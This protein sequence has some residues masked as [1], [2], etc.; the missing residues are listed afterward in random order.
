MSLFSA[1]IG[2]AGGAGWNISFGQ[3]SANLG[4]QV[5]ELLPS[6][7]LKEPGENVTVQATI[8]NN[9]SADA[10]GF[11]VRMKYRAE[12]SQDLQDLFC[13]PASCNNL[14]LSAGKTTVAFGTLDTR[15]LSS[16]RYLILVEIIQNSVVQ[17]SQETSLLI[18][19]DRPEFHPTSLTFSPP[20]PAPKGSLLTVRVQIENT[21]KPVS[22][23]L[24]NIL[25]TLE[26]KFEYCQEITEGACVEFSSQGFQDGTGGTI[27][28]TSAELGALSTGQPLQVTNR[29]DTTNLPTGTYLFRVGVRGVDNL[30]GNE[31]DELDN[32]NNE[33][34][35]HLRIDPPGGVGP[36]RPIC[37]LSG[38]VNALAKGVGR[39]TVKVVYLGIDEVGRFDLK[40][41][42]EDDVE[43]SGCQVVPKSLDPPLASGISM[44]SFLFDQFQLL[45]VGLSN[46]EL[47]VVDLKNTLNGVDALVSRKVRV[48]GTSQPLMSLSVRPEGG[49]EQVFIGTGDGRLY[50]VS[51]PR[52]SSSRIQSPSVQ[53]CA[54]V[55]RAINVVRDFQGNIYFGAD[56]GALY[57]MSDVACP[58][59]PSQIFTAP[60]A[61]TTLDVDRVLSFDTTV[62]RIYVGT[63]NGTVHAL[64][65][66]GRELPKSPMAF[67]AEI[68]QLQSNKLDQ[69]STAYAATGDGKVWCI[70]MQ[71]TT[72]KPS[73]ESDSKQAINTLAI[74]KETGLVFAGSADNNLYVLNAACQRR[75]KRSTLGPIKA[76][77]V[78]E[79]LKDF[80]GSPTEIRAL[81]GGGNGLYSTPI[82]ISTA[83]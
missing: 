51:V 54:N 19:V 56:N 10:Q 71:T 38:S 17:S 18:G 72:V 42:T 61:V 53:L 35:T 67:G 15:A 81:Y 9:G 64:A 1:V 74:D 79:V 55:S 34:I 82:P 33:I 65:D 48:S 60:S 23:L 47:L 2:L 75:D 7:Y 31:L 30:S 39:S 70:D 62:L 25:P 68:K 83:D 52:D 5:I 6:S 73:F 14:S 58:G 13:L 27:R 4:I 24:P 22:L 26:V 66:T 29:L 12:G 46:G 3:A 63:K 20:S 69:Q 59:T 36:N 77:M 32:G 80:F 50:R 16:G 43:K 40:A 37:Q 78:L 21:G 44:R 41:F 11:S 76:N 28:R 8:I 45:Y 57:R 49:S